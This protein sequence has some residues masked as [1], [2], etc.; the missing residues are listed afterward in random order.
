MNTMKK[1]VLVALWIV[2]T[3][4]TT[5]VAYVAVN[6]AG[7]EVTDRPLT[8]VVATDDSSASSNTSTT[9]QAGTSTSAADGTSTSTSGISTAGGTGTTG[10]TSGS[11]TSTSSS[12]T[13]STATTGTTLSDDPWQQTTIPSK[14][15]LVIVSYRPG[16]VRLESIAPTPGFSYEIDDQ[17]PPEVRVEFGGGDVKVEVRVR[18]DGGLVT[19]VDEDN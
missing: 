7:A 14:G 8:S 2:A 4:A 11:T 9:G 5:A 18:W 12:S 1:P 6:A 10:T 17:G 13:S 19:E 15:G 16:E 3:L